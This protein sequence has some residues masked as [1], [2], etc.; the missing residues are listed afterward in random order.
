M[1]QTKV[2]IAPYG[3]GIFSSNVTA[4]DIVSQLL[5][6]EVEVSLRPTVSRPV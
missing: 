4:K 5:N 1:Q 2:K 3:N 6:K